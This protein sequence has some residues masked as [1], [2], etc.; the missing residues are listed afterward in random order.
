MAPNSPARSFIHASMA[1]ARSTA[2][3]NRSKSALM[4]APLSSFSPSAARATL[5]FR[6][7]GFQPALFLE[8]GG[9]TPLSPRFVQAGRN[10]SRPGREPVPFFVFF[11]PPACPLW[12]ATRHSPLPYGAG[13]QTALLL[14]CGGLTPLSH[15]PTYSGAALYGFM[16]GGHT[17]GFPYSES[18]QSL[19]AKRSISYEHQKT[20]RLS[21][22]PRA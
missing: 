16:P 5:V 17:G 3:L 12:R 6:S 8:C 9:W 11:S 18:L 19:R 22:F 2:P 7:A 14:E 15:L 21:R 4:I 10:L 20:S 1:G 13:G